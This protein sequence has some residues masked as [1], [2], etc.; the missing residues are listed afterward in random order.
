MAKLLKYWL[1]FKATGNKEEFML[2]NIPSL[3]KYRLIA[4]F[5]VLC[6]LCVSA[7]TIFLT[8]NHPVQEFLLRMDAANVLQINSEITPLS[9]KK[10]A[11]YLLEIEG[12]RERLSILEKQELDFYWKEFAAELGTSPKG[13]LIEYN[14]FK[15][16]SV[17]QEDR[18]WFIRYTD[19]V[20]TFR[21]KPVVGY[22]AASVSGQMTYVRW[23]GVQ[24]WGYGSD[25]FGASFEYV[26]FGEIG[27]N[28]DKKKYFTPKT[29]AFV[30]N[31][32]GSVFEYSDVK[33]SVTATWDWGYVALI[34]DYQ[35]W[36]S[37]Q[38]GNIILSDK[39]PSFTQFRLHVNP[40]SWF[41]YD[42]F[43]GWL[44]SLVYDSSSAFYSH[45]ESVE[46]Q[47][48]MPYKDKYVV[49]NM[50]TFSLG[51]SVDYSVGNA[52]VYGP[53]FRMETLLPFMYYKVMDHNTGRILAD[54]GNGMLF[55]DLKWKV[56]P[57]LKLYGSL[58][59]D[60]INFRDLLNGE[61]DTQWLGFTVGSRKYNLFH[62]YLDLSVEYTRLNPW[63][64]ENRN[65]L[66]SYK[67][68]GYQLGHWIGQNADQLRIQ[69]DYMPIRGLRTK[70]FAEFVRK[71]EEED[72]IKAYKLN[73][74]E[75]VPFLSGRMRKDT[76]LG[77]HAE[78]EPMHD[79]KFK[80]WIEYTDI[81]DEVPGRT[82]SW[83]LGQNISFGLLWSYGL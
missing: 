48:I 58:F 59:I 49:G 62:D 64:Y 23:P 71:G 30:N 31:Q 50:A 38:F 2:D 36:G 7:Q 3:K 45:P 13:F 54:D 80:T 37:G 4:V 79:L 39:A 57:D 27:E 35:R 20:F 67:H 82:P 46:P 55:A 52:F 65:E 66:A 44:N 40:V 9:R 19:S 78:Y 43:Q 21:V 22:G 6:N 53:N 16:A 10:V 74:Y 18:F 69:L 14:P 72:I 11:E 42:Y 51:E 83:Q 68:L 29:G 1:I 61:F 33:G 77:F 70:A 17:F 81:S 60:V 24:V 73:K 8:H 25:W 56:I 41:R 15:R 28:T 47:V 5:F 26:D 75:P 32:T 63:L 34:K 76:R 12:K